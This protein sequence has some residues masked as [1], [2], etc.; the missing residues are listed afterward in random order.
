MSEKLKNIKKILV[1]RLGAIGDIVHTTATYQALSRSYENAHID[2]L[3]GAAMLDI[4]ADDPL[5]NRV[6]TL[7]DR[8]YKSYFKLYNFAKCIAQEPY[9]LIVNLQPSAKT[10]FLT[11]L[12]KPRNCLTYRKF[13]PDKHQNYI[14]AVDN[15]LKTVRPVLPEIRLPEKLTL[16]VDNNLKL[17]AH[18][19]FSELQVDQ[20]IG[21]IPGV[22]PKRENKLWPD[23]HWQT[24]LVHLTQNL[25]L[26][27]VILGGS[28]ELKIAE[29]L[30]T[31]NRK[32][33]KNLCNKYNLNQLKAVLSQ[34]NLVI[35]T[36]TGPTH[37]AT[38][39]APRVIALY[40]PTSPDR[41]GPFGINHLVVRSSYSCNCCEKRTCKYMK[42]AKSFSP[43]M[44]AVSVQ[45]VID[46]LPV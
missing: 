8:T 17:L 4:I 18:K 2:F 12:L 33:I 46:K 10:I 14:H 29:K 30:E 5:L 38:A 19:D 31:I 25:N 22:S 24:L 23:D 34:C 11:G 43:C 28:N 27:V 42:K 6:I 15:Y 41:V 40:G 9:D 36:D 35:G 16:P 44:E 37:I 39:V 3:T 26:D 45:E 7:D 32:K 21:I 13:K 1:I 20:P